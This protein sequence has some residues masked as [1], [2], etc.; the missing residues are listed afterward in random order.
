M[1]LSPLLTFFF[2]LEISREQHR[3]HIFTKLKS[4]LY[5][6]NIFPSIPLSTD[7]HQ[8]R[9]ERISTRLF[10]V[11]LV[12]SLYILLV[13]IALIDVSQTVYIDS[14]TITRYRQL[15]VSH[16]HTLT[17]ACTQITIT[18]DRFLRIQ[19]TLHQVCT[20]AFVTNAWIDYLNTYSLSRVTYDDFRWTGTT[21][22]QGL[23]SLCELVNRTISVRLTQFYS[24][25][26]IGVSV[27][28]FEVFQSEIY[29]F[30]SQF[31]SSMT[32]K[33]LLSFSTI[34]NS[35][36][37]NTILSAEQSNAALYFVTGETFLS[38]QPNEYVNCSCKGSAW[39]TDVS[40]IYHYP[41]S[42]IQHVVPG[43]YIG[44]YVIESLLQSNLHCFY[45]QICITELQ[46]FLTSPSPLTVAPL[47][48]SLLIQFSEHSS[49]RDLLDQ[50][51]IEEWTLS[52]D[53][54]QYYNE[55][56]P[57]RCSYTYETKNSIVYILT[58]LV[59]LIGGLIKVL[60]LVIPV[61]IKLARRKKE[62]TRPVTR[63]MCQI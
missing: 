51:M 18:Y 38:S 56:R 26:Y 40:A 48:A 58:T 8:L 25:R 24:S 45:D 27:T 11:L 41:N 46:S 59:G 37:V 16:S 1:P 62:S 53:Y 52:I 17:C 28:P 44:C 32:N 36:Q 39:C 13:F 49:I 60:K 9:N 30:V 47:D 10:I 5:A 29:S 20:S 50:L 31:R 3:R 2:C 33:F 4:F 34:G 57:S 54:D 15:Y 61:L 43:I 35:T 23:S 14:P 21:T 42:T 6:F 55:C 22:F 19:Y 63:K 12:L 7:P